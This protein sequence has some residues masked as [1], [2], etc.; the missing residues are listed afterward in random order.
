MLIDLHQDLYLYSQWTDMFPNTDQV[1]PQQIRNFDTKLIVASAYA[2]PNSESEY[3]VTEI[4][5]WESALDYYQSLDGFY[6]LK[7]LTDLN[8]SGN[9]GKTG[10]IFHLEGIYHEVSTNNLNDWYDRGLRSI[11]LTWA[12]TSPY[13]GGNKYTDTGLTDKGKEIIEWCLSKNILVD[14]AH[15]SEQAFGETADIVKGG[16]KPLLVSHANAR[17]VCDAGIERNLSDNQLQQVGQSGGVVGIMFARSF[18]SGQNPGS[19]GDVISHIKHIVNVAGEDCIAI[20]SDFGGL[21]SD[22]LVVG[23]E[24]FSDLDDFK[25]IIT[26]QFGSDFTEKLFYKNAQR[27]LVEYLG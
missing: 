26:N 24:K 15:M 7:D 22:P 25:T 3:G 12:E 23:L 1:S 27:V 8:L 2:G 5:M 19:I 10:I 14:L 6:I 16:N 11:G 18:V 9:E 4:E 21:I 20:G 13:A 17:S